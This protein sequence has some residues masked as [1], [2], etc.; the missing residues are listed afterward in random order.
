MRVDQARRLKELEQEN[1]GM[2]KPVPDL[3]SDN[4]IM[5][6]VEGS[7]EVAETWPPVAK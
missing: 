4:A 2:K 5:K 1:A 6:G 7:P 3:S